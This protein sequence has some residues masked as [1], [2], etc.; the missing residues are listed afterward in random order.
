[1]LTRINNQSDISYKTNNSKFT[2]ASEHPL[3][4]SAF[5]QDVEPGVTEE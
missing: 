2:I 1:M 5:V 4:V 3:Q